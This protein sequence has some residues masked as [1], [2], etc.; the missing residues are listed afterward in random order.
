MNGK[1]VDPAAD[2]SCVVRSYVVLATVN[3]VIGM[4][5]DGKFSG[6]SEAWYGCNC[7]EVSEGS[8]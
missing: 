4:T 5:T 1:T 3:G 7:K 2:Q 6:T 8:R